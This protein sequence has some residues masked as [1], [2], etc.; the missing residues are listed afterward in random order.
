MKRRH[1]VRPASLFDIANSTSDTAIAC[2]RD[3]LLRALRAARIVVSSRSAD[4]NYG[5][6]SAVRADARRLGFFEK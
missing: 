5:A 2:S 1:L 6:S 3:R 4:G